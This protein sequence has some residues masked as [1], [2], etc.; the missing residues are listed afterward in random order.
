[1]EIRLEDSLEAQFDTYI[2]E[3]ETM[4]MSQEK[5]EPILEYRQLD[6]A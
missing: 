4:E 2:D 6:S 3:L 5:S 1:M